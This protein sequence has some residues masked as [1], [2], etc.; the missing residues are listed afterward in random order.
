MTSARI[1]FPLSL[2]FLFSCEKESD[3]FKS[4]L[5]KQENDFTIETAKAWFESTYLRDNKEAGINDNWVREVFWENAFESSFPDKRKRFVSTITIIPVHRQ[6][7][8]E[9]MNVRKVLIMGAFAITS[10]MEI[11]R[12]RWLKR[13][14]EVAAEVA[15]GQEK[16]LHQNNKWYWIIIIPDRINHLISANF[17]VLKTLLLT[18][19]THIR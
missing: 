1:L 18:P 8:T 10:R 3:K 6:V 13:N 14:L 17:L 9:L 5:V 4:S 11:I 15:A 12:T 19:D 16:P 2:L 7:R